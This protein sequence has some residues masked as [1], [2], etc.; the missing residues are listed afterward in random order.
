M[1][2]TRQTAVL[3][4][5]LSYS[6]AGRV[7]AE[8]VGYWRFDEGQ[9][10]AV[11]DDSGRDNHGRIVGARWVEGLHG[12]GLEFSG[13]ETCYVEIPHSDSLSPT[14]AVTVTAWAK[15]HRCHTWHSCLVYKT[16]SAHVAPGFSDRCY[17]LWAT[18]GGLHFTSTPDGRPG[19]VRGDAWG[20]FYAPNEFTHFAMV[21]DC[22]HK[23]MSG[24]VNGRAVAQTPYSGD[25]IRGGKGP[26]R[27]GGF[28]RSNGDQSGL[29]GVLDEVRIYDHA[30]TAR[31]I[32]D[33]MALGTR[34]VVFR[35][36]FEA[37]PGP[38]WNILHPDPTHY[39][40]DRK[41]GTLTIT[42]QTGAF[43]GAR[44]GYKNLFLTDVPRETGENYEITIRVSD[45]KPDSPWCQAGLVCWADEDNFLKWTYECYRGR[46][47][48]TVVRETANESREMQDQLE[49]GLETI[50]L[51]ITKRG[52]RFTFSK[53]LDGE[54]FD[55]VR[56]IEWTGPELER[57]GLVAQ[58]GPNPD[59]P[60]V[61][62]LFDFIEVVGI[63]AGQIESP[64]PQPAQNPWPNQ[65]PVRTLP[66][67]FRGWI[68]IEGNPNV[69]LIQPGEGWHVPEDFVV[70]EG[71]IDG[72]RR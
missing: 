30:L 46:N 49:Q 15:V 48:F 10:L 36:D 40:L 72:R 38:E 26:L 64:S 28:W 35:D 59:A 1:P 12:F 23:M 31:E 65:W 2:G 25:R 34:R 58:N 54:A 7:P 61:D 32:A 27:L 43:S 62:V 8:L 67:S 70:R 60:E 52:K 4:L 5:I 47:A 37:A 51:R 29:T 53:S 69:I 56:A 19:Q 16:G 6:F 24:Y 20:R 50:W 14:A 71:D 39:S 22:A 68:Q 41:R 55:D 63:G 17:T 57:I 33:D 42:T 21:V 45:F 3:C 44:K 13:D 66:G 18:Q 11:R 9:G